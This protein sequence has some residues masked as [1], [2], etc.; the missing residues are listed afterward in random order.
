M[1]KRRNEKERKVRVK[2]GEE[3]VQEDNFRD[4]CYNDYFLLDLQLF[5]CHNHE[6]WKTNSL[7]LLYIYFQNSS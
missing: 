2:R 3:H 6:L 7:Y 1:R 5:F 4:F